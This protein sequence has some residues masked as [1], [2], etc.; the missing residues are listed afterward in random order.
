M[1][2][3]IARRTLQT[4]WLAHGDS[5]QALKS[6]FEDARKAKWKGPLD[7]KATYPKASVVGGNRVV[8]N[9]VGGKYRLVVKFHYNTGVAYI[10]FIGTHKMYDQID[11]ERI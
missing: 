1:M 3:I 2:R 11:V 9:I 4:F 7:I 10:R 8:F 6:W 5:E